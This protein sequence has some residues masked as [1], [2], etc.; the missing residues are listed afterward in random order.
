MRIHYLQHVPFEGPGHVSVAAKKKELALSCTRLYD[1][2][3]LPHVSSFDLLIVLGGPMGVY[4]N[5]EYPWLGPEKSFIEKTLAAGKKMIGL[6]LGAQILAHVLGAPVYRNRYPEIGWFPV[7]R[8][9]SAVSS[10]IGK[11][12]P[13]TFQAFHWHNDTFDIPRGAVRLAKSIA[14]ENQGFVYEDRAMGLQFHLESTAESIMQIYEN[15]GGEVTENMFVQS[16]E[17]ALNSE[18]ISESN[19]LFESIISE[20]I[21]T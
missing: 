8:T 14:T 2:Q 7:T 1:G 17:E 4:D 20:F 15:S 19:M 11:I 3:Q 16:R 10:R 18:H 5:S 21:K 9:G 6:C 13:D 12:L